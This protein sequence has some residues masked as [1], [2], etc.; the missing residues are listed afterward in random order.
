MTLTKTEMRQHLFKICFDG[1][2]L[3]TRHSQYIPEEFE[4][5]YSEEHTIIKD[6]FPKLMEFYNYT[7]NEIQNNLEKVCNLEHIKLTKE[8]IEKYE[9]GYYKITEGLNFHDKYICF[10]DKDLIKWNKILNINLYD[11]EFLVH[12]SRDI[13]G[14]LNGFGLRLLGNRKQLVEN[15][16][17]WLF[18]MGQHC[19][20]GLQNLNDNKDIIL[21]EGF[22]DY[23]AASESGYYNVI[24]LGS[25]DITNG[26]K[27]FLPENRNYHFCYDQ[28][29]YGYRKKKE[30]KQFVFFIPEKFKD[31]YEAFLN[32]GKVDFI[33]SG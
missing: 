3:L 27:Y 7:I 32:N 10:S 1:Y 17:K 12:F 6:G 22:S 20:F 15:S 13:N 29:G 19:T 26:H 11:L 9:I 2:D 31:P 18:P 16:F 8:L 21:V 30:F 14:N 23:M 25:I 28:D 33:I 4:V 5:K 24:G